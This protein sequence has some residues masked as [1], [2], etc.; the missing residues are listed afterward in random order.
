MVS[1][2]A[3]KWPGAAGGVRVHLTHRL[4]VKQRH[5]EKRQSD[6]RNRFGNILEFCRLGR[7]TFRL[8]RPPQKSIELPFEHA[9]SDQRRH[10]GAVDLAE[11]PPGLSAETQKGG[12]WGSGGIAV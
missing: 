3:E 8:H 6:P 9:H 10:D 7:F 1:T 11:E 4:V 2:Y 5:P 12:G